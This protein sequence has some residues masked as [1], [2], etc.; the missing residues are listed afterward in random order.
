MEGQDAVDAVHAPFTAAG[1]ETGVDALLGE[2]FV[3]V[4]DVRQLGILQ[5]EQCTACREVGFALAVDEEAELAD[6]S[7]L[8]W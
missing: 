2:E 3:D 6:P 5:A 1:A 8:R 7:E 4:G